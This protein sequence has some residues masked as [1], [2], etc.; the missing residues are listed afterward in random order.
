MCQ[1]RRPAKPGCQ[2]VSSDSAT[3]FSSTHCSSSARSP[4]HRSRAGSG[5]IAMGRSGRAVGA[6]DGRSRANG[7]PVRDERWFRAFA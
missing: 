5:A 3:G 1:E 6:L 2:R 4:S 7:R